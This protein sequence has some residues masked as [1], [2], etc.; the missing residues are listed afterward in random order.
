MKMHGT[1]RPTNLRKHHN[2]RSFGTKI[3][4][5]TFSILHRGQWRS[6]ESS[7]GMEEFCSPCAEDM[8]QTREH[9]AMKDRSTPV[10]LSP[11]SNYR[12]LR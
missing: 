2:C 11:T 3:V 5:Q 8:T 1:L 12:L 10:H 4:L 6:S 7:T 9:T